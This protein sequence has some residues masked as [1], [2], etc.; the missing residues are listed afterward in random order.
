MSD[1]RS[2]TGKDIEDLA[3]KL[4][5]AVVAEVHQVYGPLPPELGD[6]LARAF[7]RVINSGMYTSV[8]V[9]GDRHLRQSSI[10]ES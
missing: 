8:D 3:A 9:P 1:Y 2:E 5:R 4:A 6:R 7:T 10:I